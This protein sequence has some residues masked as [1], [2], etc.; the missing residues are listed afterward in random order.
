MPS[1]N[2]QARLLVVDDDLLLRD[3][4]GRSL[5]HAGFDV[6]EVDSG[7]SALA[8]LEQAPFDLL[9]LDVQMRGI[10]G[11]ETCRR[12]R[13]LAH[14]QHVPVLI[15]TGLD[16]T[17]SIEQAHQ[18][19]A[20]DFITK[21]IHWGLLVYRVR[22]ALRG[23]AASESIRRS[24][25]SM[26]RAQRMAHLGNWSIEAGGHMGCSDELA[27]IFGAPPEAAQC[28]SAEAFLQ[29]VGDADRDRVRAAREALVTSGQAYQLTFTIE[30]FDG[31]TRTVF[32]Q[33]A[34]VRDA[35]GRQVAVE[36]ITH[37]I[38]ERVDAERRIQ[39]MALHD[40]LTGLPNREFFLRLAG[41]TLE[42]ARHGKTQCAVL[43]IDMDR[44]KSINDALGN[45][46]GNEVLQIVAQRLQHHL[47]AG[48]LTASAR[49]TAPAGVLARVGGNA[50]TVLL[51]DIG[52]PEH[53]A[54]AADRLARAIAAPITVGGT[55]VRITASVGMALFPRDTTEPGQLVRFA[56]QALYA[57]KASGSGQQRFFDEA[58]NAQA[59]A[60]LARES[61]LRRAIAGGELRLYLQP[62]Y[63]AATGA[64]QGAEALVRWQHPERGLL[65]PGEFIA[66]A[67][68]TG[69]ITALT[70][71][72]LDQ[73]GAL[74]AR[75]AAA[76]LPGVS[77]AVNVAAPCFMADDLVGDLAQLVR[78]H[79]MSP[80]SL[81]LEVTESML[82]NDL[83][84]AV[85]RLHALHA[86]GFKLSLDDFGTGYSSL[87]YLKRF[88]IDELKIDRSFVMDVDQGDKGGALIAAIVTLAH[89]MRMQVV[90]EGVE[91]AGQAAALQR[92]GCDVHQ[93]Y[94]YA[95]PMPVEA[96]EKLLSSA[97]QGQPSHVA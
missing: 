57:A 30:R 59:S 3:M 5:R 42:E 28:A 27:R 97:P 33:A 32:E 54:R 87:A 7:E 64:M 31:I 41:R 24:R 91:T 68:E 37:D 71:W 75:C 44:F 20:T 53:A 6:T 35:V 25:E 62:K 73:V 90:A 69:Q 66:L 13:R 19:G 74:S 83:D 78:R 58:M 50:F 65:L 34:P 63:L 40:G 96:F 23:A 51:S 60:R 95:R 52:R 77:L 11:F 18:A 79:G 56:E 29:R 86:Q 72:V 16:D 17:A 70:A 45:D 81:V 10:D 89:L 61:E 55:E 46:A 1:N 48:D 92:L 15:L 88:P 80:S 21:P 14:G 36:G 94:F 84:R 49:T 9:L 22:Y 8:A 26:A 2:P 76:G 93:G 39:H 82:M 85:D 67:E 38:T 43:Q 12:L 47:R 4:A